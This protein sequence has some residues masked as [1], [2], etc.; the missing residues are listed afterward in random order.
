MKRPASHE[1]ELAGGRP[2]ALNPRL[3]HHPVGSPGRC[4]LHV[5]G[6]DHLVRTV[7][8]HRYRETARR[9]YS[10]G[11]PEKGRGI[12]VAVPLPPGPVVEN[13]DTG[14]QPLELH[15]TFVQTVSVARIVCR[16]IHHHRRMKVRSVIHAVYPVD[17]GIFPFGSVARIAAHGA[18]GRFPTRIDIRR[19]AHVQPQTVAKRIETVRLESSVCNDAVIPLRLEACKLGCRG[20]FVAAHRITYGIQ[21]D[22]Q[23][24]D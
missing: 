16:S 14:S 19:I 17:V 5:V 18:T 6:H 23:A 8:L 3:Q 20:P 2:K 11:M 24:V 21:T 10:I 7:P 9:P 15:I 13:G 22:R 1:P 12:H 4:Q